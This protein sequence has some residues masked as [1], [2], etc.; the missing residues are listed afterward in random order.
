MERLSNSQKN[1]RGVSNTDAFQTEET[2]D[3]P[4]RN[5]QK[6]IAFSSEKFFDEEKSFKNE[7]LD[8][9]K[10]DENVLNAQCRK[11]S[12]RILSESGAGK[13]AWINGA[14]LV[15]SIKYLHFQ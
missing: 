13:S 7:D 10:N 6:T 14:I 1:E 2:E 5:N 9:L 11:I 3:E 4:I 15:I 8:L 12:I